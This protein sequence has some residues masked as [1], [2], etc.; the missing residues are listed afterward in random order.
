MFHSYRT[1]PPAKATTEWSRFEAVLQ[2]LYSLFPVA[3]P[4]LLRHN[5]MDPLSRFFFHDLIDVEEGP[6]EPLC[7]LLANRRL[8]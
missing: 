2:M 4:A 3:D 6:S 8:S 5:I 7:D 1:V